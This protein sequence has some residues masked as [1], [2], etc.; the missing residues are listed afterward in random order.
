MDEH[1]PK[2]M[3]R[4]K[5]TRTKHFTNMNKM[6]EHASKRMKHQKKTRTKHFTNMNKMDEHA[7]KRMKHQKKIVFFI[8]LKRSMEPICMHVTS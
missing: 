4:Q 7:P 6:D 3:K 5:K 1:A 2:R 8:M